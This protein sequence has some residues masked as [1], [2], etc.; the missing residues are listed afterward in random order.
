MRLLGV[1]LGEYHT[2]HDFGLY[3]LP[4]ETSVNGAEAESYLLQVQGSDRLLDLTKGIYDKVHYKQRKITITLKT[5]KP[6][7][8]WPSIQRTLENSFQGQWLRCIFDDD[9]SWYWEG[10]WTVEPQEKD[11]TGAVF[12]ITGVCN[13]YKVSLT[14]AAGNDWLWDTFNFETDTI[15]TKPTEVKSL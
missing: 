2:L 1:K 6:P 14:A 3:L 12:T 4:G 9:P 8:F 13:P 10:L 5:F 15:Y 11:K 7:K